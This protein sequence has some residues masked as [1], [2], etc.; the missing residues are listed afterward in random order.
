MNEFLNTENTKLPWF[1]WFIDSYKQK[2]A[3]QNRALLTEEEKGKN[4][5]L[6]DVLQV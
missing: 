3:K 2:K 1:S 4:T 6:D 5:K